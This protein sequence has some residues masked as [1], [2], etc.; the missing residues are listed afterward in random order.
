VRSTLAGLVKFVLDPTVC[1]EFGCTGSLIEGDDQVQYVHSYVR[2]NFPSPFRP[3]EL[4]MRV[5]VYQNPHTKEVTAWAA[6]APDKVPRNECCVR[7]TQ[8]NNTWR[9]TPLGNGEVE[10]EYILNMDEGGFMPDLLLNTF[11]A[12]AMFSVFPKL[13]KVLNREKYQNAKFDYIKE[14]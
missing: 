6:A 1:P 2:Y 13:Q 10:V 8:M 11:R 9:Y 5:M 3:R 12:K 7:V 4:V 14:L